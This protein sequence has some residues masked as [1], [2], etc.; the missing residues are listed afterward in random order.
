L[1][2]KNTEF[3]LSYSESPKSLSHLGFDRYQ[4]VTDGRTDGLNC[5]STTCCRA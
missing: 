2:E 3:T 4:D 5:Y 1:S